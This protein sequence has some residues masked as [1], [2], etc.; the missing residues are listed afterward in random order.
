MIDISEYNVGT[1]EGRASFLQD[2]HDAFEQ[3]DK[4]LDDATEKDKATVSAVRDELLAQCDE[5]PLMDKLDDWDN[6]I[7]QIV[8]ENDVNMA[9]K[10]A[11][12]LQER[13]EYWTKYAAYVVSREVALKNKAISQSANRSGEIKDEMKE[14]RDSMNALLTIATTFGDDVESLG[15]PLKDDGSYAGQ[16]RKG[17]GTGAGRKSNDSVLTFYREGEPIDLAPGR[18]I[19]EFIFQHYNPATGSRV[20]SVADFE[21][22]VLG[23]SLFQT[24]WEV[25]IFSCDEVKVNSES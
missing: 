5:L 12:V 13:A 19:E 17:G 6:A 24:P 2:A 10:V 9:I 20:T 21:K 1:A 15:L 22:N 4:S 11:Q 14:L 18:K 3:M 7:N 8:G 16:L 23:H 25:D